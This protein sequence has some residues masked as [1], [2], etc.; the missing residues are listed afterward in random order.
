MAAACRDDLQ[1]SAGTVDLGKVSC[2]DEIAAGRR[3]TVAVI[4][5]A[6]LAAS[7][8]IGACTFNF[9][10]FALAQDAHVGADR[11]SG[12]AGGTASSGTHQGGSGGAASASGGAAGAR[13]AT[14]GAAGALSAT[15]GAAGIATTG[16]QSGASAGGAAS[17]GNS[18][19]GGSSGSCAG[20]ARGGICWYLGSAGS[21]CQQVCASH[22]QPAPG[23][24][25]HVGTASQGGSLSEC[26][27]LLGLL[28]ASGAPASGTRSDGLGLGCH[29][30]NAAP[31]WLSAPNFSVSASHASAKLVC[32][33]AQ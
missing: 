1:D 25:T 14:G 9:D 16:G 33:C 27:T 30:Y 26:T 20:P 18:S 19:T 11:S 23:A 32:G 10:R 31:W 12:G 29:I 13:T 24:A 2:F 7:V 5:L 22:G 4:G 21:S 28:G 15:G 8:G 17:G 3:A 6:A